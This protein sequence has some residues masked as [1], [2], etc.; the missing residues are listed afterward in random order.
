M[1][2]IKVQGLISELLDLYIER[3]FNSNHSLYN[4]LKKE[5]K[6]EAVDYVR[7]LLS[8]VLIFTDRLENVEYSVNCALKYKTTMNNLFAEF[9][10]WKGKSLKKIS[11]MIGNDS[12]CF[13]FDS[14]EGLQEDWV[15]TSM[16]KGFF[17]VNKKTPKID[18]PN[19]KFYVGYFDKTIPDFVNFL[20]KNQIEQILFIHLDSDTYPAANIV[21]NSLSKFIRKNT[22][23]T[24]D[25]YLGYPGWK[26]GEYKAF[27]EFI[28]DYNMKYKYLSFSSES[29]T[30]QIL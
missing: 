6:S 28:R 18:N 8:D 19:C 5:S 15:G 3:K 13:G 9:G 2:K 10:V 23:I 17:N 21:L 25:E 4:L 11:K 1:L 24:F 12:M 16:A 29:A 22:I 26:Y 27:Q 14:F 7:P 30:I 20:D